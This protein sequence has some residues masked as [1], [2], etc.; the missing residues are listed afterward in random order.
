MAGGPTIKLNSGHEI[1]QI[2]LGTWL[3]KPNEVAKA[4]ESALKDG[5]RHIDGA[6]IYQNENEVGEGWKAS[7]VP[8]EEIF[9]TT[10]NWNNARTKEGV[11]KQLA[12]SLKELQTD[13]VDLLLIHWPVV[14]KTGEELFPHNA[15]GTVALGEVPVEETWEAFEEL[16]QEGKVKS[17]GVSNFTEERIEK[18]LKTAKIPPAVNQIEYHPYLQQPGLAKYLESKNIV[19]EAYS[20]LGNNTYGF[21]RAIDDKRVIELAEKKGKDAAALIVNWI[22]SKNH[23]VLPKSVTPSRIKSNFEVFDLSPEEIKFLDGLDEESRRNDPI[24]WGVDI[25]GTA[26]PEEV[27]KRVDEAA[28]KYLAEQKK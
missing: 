22:R 23:V 7:G 24:E 12:Q 8:R 18:L 21:P 11:K 26:T 3:S 20:P 9:L 6:T 13:Y 14:F 17:I 19:L 5:Y 2:G 15:D 25:F 10:K 16:V 1:P 28:K 27:K 4:V